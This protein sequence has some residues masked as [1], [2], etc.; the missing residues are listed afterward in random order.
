LVEISF[1]IGFI[2]SVV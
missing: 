2:Q 1:G